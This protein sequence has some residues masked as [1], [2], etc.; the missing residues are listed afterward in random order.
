MK[1]QGQYW[2]DKGR[3]LMPSIIHWFGVAQYLGVVGIYFCYTMTGFYRFPSPWLG[4]TMLISGILILLAFDSQEYRYQAQ[5]KEPDRLT[6]AIIQ[7]SRAVVIVLFSYSDGLGLIHS[8]ILLPVIFFTFFYLCGRSYHLTGLVWMLYLIVRVHLFADSNLNLS[9]PGQ[10]NDMTRDYIFVLILAFILTMAYQA[11]R[12]RANRLR[13]EKLLSE[14]E[15]SHRQLQD[16]AEKVA[17]LATIEERNRLARDIHD[18]LGHY[19]TVINVQLEKAIAFR[20]RNQQEADQAVRDS[21]RLASEALQDVRR[22]VSALRNT[23]ETFPLIQSVTGLVNNLRSGKLSIELE[24]EG[25][26]EGFSQQS[27]MTLYRAAQEGLTNIQKH[28]QA[29]CAVVSFKFNDQLASL[30]IVDNGQGV[31]ADILGADGTHFGLKGV[32]E[33][34][35]LIHGSLE[36][37]SAPGKGMKLFITVPKNP[38]TQIAWKRSIV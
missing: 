16:Y 24:I 36:L 9:W 33:R 1:Q 14:L 38:L 4:G 34:L 25:S 31:D 26:E 11:K 13:V 5:E 3:L 17:E 8:V 28:S 35:E 29:S 15:T 30:C 12:E 7:V 22:S 2:P 19:L 6:V 18:S 20:D 37:E 23:Q 21:K 10:H 27:L 32:R